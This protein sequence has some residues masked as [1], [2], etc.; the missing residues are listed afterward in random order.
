MLQRSNIKIV[1]IEP[2]YQPSLCIVVDAEEDFDWS[3]GFSRDATSVVSMAEQYR[4]QEIFAK[5]GAVPTYVVDYCI[6]NQKSSTAV[7]KEFFDQGLCDIG[8]QLHPWVN[9]P[10]EEEVNHFNSYH[11]NLPFKLEREKIK[12]LTEKIIEVFDYN[13]TVFKAGRYGVGKN[14]GKILKE[15]GYK[16]DCSVVP[17]LNESSEDGPN[18]LGLPDSPYWF[19]EEHDLLEIPL[20]R[21]FFGKSRAIG[22]VLAPLIE[23][24]FGK[25]LAFQGIFS[26]LGMFEI[27]TLTPEG[28]SEKDLLALL[29]TKV[30][31]G[32]KIISLTYHSSSLGI[33]GS[34]YVKCEEDRTLFLRTLDRI[35]DVFVNEL[36]GRIIPITKLYDEFKK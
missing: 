3:K 20:S 35:L 4:A 1:D 12:H 21:V 23:S 10:F 24:A 17:Y 19:G 16:I 34:P 6:V 32:H 18:F 31:D 29:R 8:A 27:C 26:K 14:T 9:P 11:G 36:G 28:R 7:V 2:S 22:P 5:Y 15:L 33:N 30:N 25:R 13:P